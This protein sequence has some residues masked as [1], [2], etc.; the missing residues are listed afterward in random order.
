[1]TGSNL[2]S[3]I[4]LTYLEP[5]RGLPTWVIA[6]LF[7][8]P[9]VGGIAFYLFKTRHARSWR[10]GIYPQKLKLTEDNL[11][12]AYLALGS[13]IILIDY[14]S[15]KG[16]AQTIN[17]YFNRYFKKSNYNFGDS[18]LFSMRHPIQIESVNSWLLK[19]LHTEGERSQVIYFL[20]GIA[21]N[22]GTLSPRELQF[23]DVMNRSLELPKETLERIVSMQSNF[24]RTQNKFK[25]KNAKK[26][27]DPRIRY[28]QILHLPTH[29]TKA[30][31]KSRY[32][33]LVKEHHPDKFDRASEAQK[34]LAKE[35]FQLI[36]EAYDYFVDN[37][38]PE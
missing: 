36:R 27:N 4:P 37:P 11:L 28:A 22:D 1:M 33:S 38:S 14:P 35:N 8:V 6:L 19:H 9:F 10:K 32:R 17:Q 23:L 26:K 24:H 34:L 25:I 13:L 15:S 7:F 30:E 12:E 2:L 31:L 18:L 5:A 3:S 29:P 20:A 16:K 21:M